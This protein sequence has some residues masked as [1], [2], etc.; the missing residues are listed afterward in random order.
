MF[1]AKKINCFRLQAEDWNFDM[2]TALELVKSKLAKPLDAI[3]DEVNIGWASGKSELILDVNEDNSVVGE[4]LYLSCRIAVKK[5]PSGI[6]N[7]LLRKKI[8]EYMTEN[9][10]D[11]VSGKVKKELKEEVTEFLLPRVMPT[12]K[13]VWVVVCPDGLVLVGSTRPND[14][15]S[16][17]SLFMDTFDRNLDRVSDFTIDKKEFSEL[18]FLT[19]L[20]RQSDMMI[21]DFSVSAPFTFVSTTEDDVS[22]GAT[23][24]GEICN[25]STEVASALQNK[26]L[27][28]KVKLSVCGDVENASVW[29]FT[30]DGNGGL[31]SLQCPE[32]E[33]M[34]FKTVFAEKVQSIRDLFTWIDD[35][36]DDFNSDIEMEAKFNRWIAEK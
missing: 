26:K 34:D 12:V 35:R 8:T 1:E 24:K 19:D 11:Y 2:Q 31:S 16:V 17:W 33:S 20:F 25:R 23:V 18:Y 15:D 36:F 30:L 29:T 27:L 13:S 22:T 6:A 32:S 3:T 4:Y 14:I 7:A 21:A 28:K 5:I 9:G 10:V